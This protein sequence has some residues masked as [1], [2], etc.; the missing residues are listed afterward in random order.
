MVKIVGAYCIRPY[1]ISSIT[2]E[3][4]CW[5]YA[6]RPYKCLTLS[7]QGCGGIVFGA[8]DIVFGDYEKYFHSLDSES[9]RRLLRM[10]LTLFYRSYYL[11]VFQCRKRFSCLRSKSLIPAY[12]ATKLIVVS[13]ELKLMSFIPNRVSLR[14]DLTLFYPF[15]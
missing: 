10:D 14:M 2:L 1:K 4:R 8:N 13:L 11:F 6:I 12:K 3:F 15:Y 9:H 7:S 5:A